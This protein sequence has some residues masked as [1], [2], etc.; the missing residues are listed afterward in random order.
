MRKVYAIRKIAIFSIKVHRFLCTM[1]IWSN[2]ILRKLF[3]YKCC[4]LLILTQK[5]INK[6]TLEMINFHDTSSEDE[7]MMGVG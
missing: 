1:L 5:I 7:F 6:K 2:L 3:T 4:G